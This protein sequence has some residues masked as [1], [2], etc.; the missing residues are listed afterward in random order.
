MSRRSVLAAACLCALGWAAPAARAAP[1]WLA[2]QT[3]SNPADP[4]LG[5]DEPV[6]MGADGDI[7][8]AWVQ[9]GAIVVA[10]RP[11]GA[12]SFSWETVSTPGDDVYLPNVTV[13][14]AGGVAAVWL[15]NTLHQYEIAVR[16]PGGTFSAPVQAGSFGAGA[17]QSTSVAIDDAGDVL[18]GETQQVGSSFEAAYAWQ[19]AGGTLAVTSL[20]EPAAEEA[21]APVVAM[22]GAG[23]AIL[24]WETSKGGAGGKHAIEAIARAAGGAF[25]APQT[26]VNSSEYAFA[27]ATAMGSA[28]QAA[29]AWEYGNG[30]SQDRIQASSSAARADLLSVPQTISSAGAQGEYPAIA[31][32]GNGEVVAAWEQ[33]GA[34][35]VEDA[36]SAPAGGGFAPS[37]E[38]SAGGS[39]GDPQVAMD[40]AGDALIA[41]GAAPAGVQR[42]DAVVRS[43]SGALGLEVTLSA[44]DEEVNFITANVPAVTVG[45]DRAGD[46][47]AGWGRKSDHTLQAR[48][49]DTGEPAPAPNGPAPANPANPAPILAAAPVLVAHCVAPSL[50]GLTGAAAKRRLLAAHCALGKLSVARRYRH[51]KRLVVAA[52]GIRAGTVLAAGTHVTVTLGPPPRRHKKRHR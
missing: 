21:Y 34:A 31:V 32:G 24:A 9:S 45:M 12:S 2:A 28:G 4:L 47:I 44:P 35:N 39:V 25:G 37:V 13:S 27:L 18:V 30:A 20:S 6:T 51:A 50:K 41:W 33:Y 17:P 3:L 15:D 36:A 11:V 14:A 43:A 38:V 7:A 42:M 46:A 49:Y 8:A 40:G 29:V 5:S 26:L 1:T 19:P 22:D 48:I 10:V 16:P 52:Q 23:D